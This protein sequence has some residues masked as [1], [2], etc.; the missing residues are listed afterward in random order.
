ME[1]IEQQDPQQP[2]SKQLVYVEPANIM[3]I[4]MAAG[5]IYGLIMVMSDPWVRFPDANV[6]INWREALLTASIMGTYAALL[7]WMVT[8]FWR[9]HLLWFVML[10]TV[11]I[12]S[13]GLVGWN[14]VNSPFG[15]ESDFL[16]FLPFVLVFHLLTIGMAVIYLNLV[17]YF[18]QRRKLA[19]AAIP[20]VLLIIT[21]MGIGRL[22]WANQDAQDVV[23]A[24]DNYATSIFEDDY[25]I[26]YFG[27]QYS[28][29]TAPTGR[30]RIY[31]PDDQR[32]DCVVRLFP[33]EAE[34]SC[35]LAQ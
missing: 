17:L 5:F 18:P 33:T 10:I 22:R 7:G 35:Q 27:M 12:V 32:L 19:Y 6:V 16:T 25:N 26:E 4:S 29:E 15:I 11:P 20:V 9:S 30:L 31:T 24:V 3:L 14:N 1:P 8:T 34:V 21:F 2:N 23:A 28:R 13:G